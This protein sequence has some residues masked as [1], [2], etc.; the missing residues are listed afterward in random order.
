MLYHLPGYDPCIPLTL[1]LCAGGHVVHLASVLG[2]LDGI[3]GEGVRAYI[4]GAKSVQELI[5]MPY[6]A[7]ELA[8]VTFIYLPP[9][10]NVA[11]RECSVLLTAV[12]SR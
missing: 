7:K 11:M 5:D 2:Q 6:P 3:N 9:C 4:R 1:H 12:R 8:E 10:T